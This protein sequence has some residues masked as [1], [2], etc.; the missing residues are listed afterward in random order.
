M[1]RPALSPVTAA[2]ATTTPTA[3][4]VVGELV[5]EFVVPKSG[6]I[7]YCTC[8]SWSFDGN[9]LYSGYTDGEIRAWHIS[10]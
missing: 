9:T 2:D 6:V 1:D 10:A 7:P 5:P 8:L 3:K 4:V